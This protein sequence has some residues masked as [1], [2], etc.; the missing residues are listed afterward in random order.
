MLRCS[1]NSVAPDGVRVTLATRIRSSTDRKRLENRCTSSLSIRARF[2][3]S[4]DANPPDPARHLLRSPPR[5]VRDE[6]PSFPPRIRNPLPYRARRA[7]EASAPVGCGRALWP[8]NTS[9]RSRGTCSTEASKR[10][11]QPALAF[12]PKI[13]R[14]CVDKGR[15]ISHSCSSVPEF[16]SAARPRDPLQRAHSSAVATRLLPCQR[17]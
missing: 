8:A 2:R 9:S 6:D 13:R 11:P 4:G 7:P 5:R 17:C 1:E 16:H 15:G 12:G 3:K 10:K 14:P